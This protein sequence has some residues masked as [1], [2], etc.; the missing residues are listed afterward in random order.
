MK[1]WIAEV[2]GVMHI[3]KITNKD[4]AAKMHVTPEYVSMLLNE[5]KVTKTAEQD[6]RA[7]I[8]TILSDRKNSVAEQ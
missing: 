2:V 6:V 3:N 8:D 7:A 4:V 1:N 5:K